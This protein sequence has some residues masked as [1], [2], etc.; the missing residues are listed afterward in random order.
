[1]T[2]KIAVLVDNNTL[3]D[4]Y[5]CGEPGVSYYIEADGRKI[6]FDTGYS[7]IFINNAHTLNI[8]LSRITD[9]ALS[10][11]HNDHTWGLNHLIQHYD[12]RNCCFQKKIDLIYH[13]D[14]L[15]PKRFGSK[16]IGAN[17]PKDVLDAYFD[18]KQTVEPYSLTE[19]IIFLGQI[20]R[21]NHFEGKEPIGSTVDAN[22]QTIDDYVW[23]DSALV[24]KTS[25]G[26]IIVTGCS[27]AGI[28]NII[29]YAKQVTNTNKV[30]TVIGGFHLQNASDEILNQTGEY[31]SQLDVDHIHPCH[32]TDLAAKIHLSKFSSIKE[33]GVGLVLNYPL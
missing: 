19:N 17:I 10:H 24:I 26:I 16:V 11:G 27:H 14:A 18:S 8:D 25:A 28:C 32:C 5:F 21:N 31:F 15:L 3:I 9:L 23:D 33:V 4:S 1:M 7:N 6:L 20:P 13:P 22:N 29:E 2:I 12:R 30:V